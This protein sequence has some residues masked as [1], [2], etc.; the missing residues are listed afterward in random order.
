MTD[1]KA[2]CTYRIGC[3]AT[4]V[5]ILIA[6][7][8]LGFAITFGI[9]TVSTPFSDSADLNTT[10][11]TTITGIVLTG[12]LVLIAFAGRGLA[13]WGKATTTRENKLRK[14]TMALK[15]ET[16][17][18]APAKT[19]DLTCW[20]CGGKTNA[21]SRFRPTMTYG[22][23]N[24]WITKTLPDVHIPRCSDCHTRQGNEF[25]TLGDGPVG[26]RYFRYWK[27]HPE[28]QAFFKA[29]W[30]FE[31]TSYFEDP[32]QEK[33]W[34]DQEL[35]K[36]KANA[37]Q[38]LQKL[39]TELQQGDDRQRRAAS[40]KLGK[41]KDPAAVSAL[42]SAFNDKDSTVRKNVVDGLRSIGSKEALDFL[43]SLEKNKPES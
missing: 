5:G 34:A 7:V 30:R 42:I 9:G 15:A 43:V 11:P 16:P 25:L 20:Y 4:V 6:V 3:F 36:K 32:D 1:T 27:E 38:K 10:M 39:I 29:G 19:G 24:A 18:I 22:R 26:K 37:D 31:I 23:G 41:I 8:A 17:E 14:E 28:I 35:Q 2:S 40:Y 12:I 33:V 21:F 13:K